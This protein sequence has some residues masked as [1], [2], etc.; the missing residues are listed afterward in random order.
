MFLLNI[1]DLEVRSVIIISSGGGGEHPTTGTAQKSSGK[2]T[3]AVWPAPKPCLCKQRLRAAKN[4]LHMLGS[5]KPPKPEFGSFPVD[6]IRNV[7]CALA[8]A[9]KATGLYSPIFDD[10]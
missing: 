6:L 4:L 3:T 8:L 10:R 2:H 5:R 1:S 9:G 7:P